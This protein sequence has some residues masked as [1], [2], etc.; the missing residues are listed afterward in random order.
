MNFVSEFYEKPIQTSGPSFVLKII[1]K[2]YSCWVS[3]L[4]ILILQLHNV[5]PGSFS[6]SISILFD[7]GS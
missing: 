6:L 2:I 4:F 3:L 1:T 7:K 5:L